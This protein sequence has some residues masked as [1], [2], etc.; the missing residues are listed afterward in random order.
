MTRVAGILAKLL[1]ANYIMRPLNECPDQVS[2]SRRGALKLLGAC[3]T[4]GSVAAAGGCAS[5]ALTAAAPRS[6]RAAPATQSL[7]EKFAVPTAIWGY[8]G[9]SPGPVLRYRQGETLDVDVANALPAPTTVHWHGLRVPIDM[10]G[11]PYISQKPIEPGARFRYRF[12]LPDAGT[13]WYHPHF[14]SHEQ[15]T[16]GLYGALIIDEVQPPQVDHDWPWVL[17]DW[18]VDNEGAVRTDF[19]DP[20]DMSH[21]GRIGNVVT[22]NGHMAM[23][24]QADPA[25]LSARAGERIRLRLINAASARIFV[26]QFN[27]VTPTIVAFDGQPVAPHPVPPNG[28]VLG[29][30][31]RADVMLDV[32]AGTVRVIDRADPRR[33]YTVREISGAGTAVSRGPVVALPPNP[34]PEPE[35]SKA[36]RHK[37]VLEGGAR[38]QLRSARVGGKE[39]PIQTLVR[40]HGMAWAM[41]GI[42]N[43]EHNHDPLIT[44]KRGSSCIVTIDNQ[45]EWPHPMH[46]HGMAFRVLSVNGTPTRYRE[47]RD[48]V[49][50]VPKGSVEIAFVA[51]SPGDW[52]FHC[53]ILQ[54]QQGGMMASVRVE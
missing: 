31:M 53:H 41:N 14:R 13:Y 24:T 16:R 4:L 17:A 36:V 34:L 28:I 8:D 19:E 48:T 11:V 3:A 51:E 43:A 6:L 25:P 44:L 2:L 52:M 5:P 45:T 40:E 9:A 37:V 7:G 12:A 26:L 42:A 32:P 23:H 46:L 35:L 54:H 22:L 29:P 20:R 47:W 21:A 30:A 33:P 18:L 49:F 38:G 15:V 50:V 1:R 10:D 39:V 27:G